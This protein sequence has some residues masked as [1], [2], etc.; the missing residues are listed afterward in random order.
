M[1]SR[2]D[3]ERSVPVAIDVLDS[4]FFHVCIGKTETRNG[5]ICRPWQILPQAL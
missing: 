3:V 2:R 5:R 1:I 4:G